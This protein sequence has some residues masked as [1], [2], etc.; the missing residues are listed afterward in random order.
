MHFTEKEQKQLTRGNTSTH[1]KDVLVKEV[2]HRQ[3]KIIE[4]EH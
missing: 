1:A 2:A 4:A 3:K